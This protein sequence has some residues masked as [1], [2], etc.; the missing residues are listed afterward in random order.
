MIGNIITGIVCGCPTHLQIA[1]GIA[2]GRKIMI[3]DFYDLGVT[4]TYNEV[5]L[6][7]GSAAAAT[8][9]DPSPI[10]SANDGLIQAIADNFDAEVVSLNRLTSTHSLALVSY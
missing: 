1:L 7:K 9:I 2:L 8:S 4:C 3:E 10:G 6:F 5:R